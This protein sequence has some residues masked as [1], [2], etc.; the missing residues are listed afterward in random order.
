[1]CASSSAIFALTPSGPIGA[2]SSAYIFAD[3]DTALDNVMNAVAVGFI[4]ELDDVMYMQFLTAHDRASYEAQQASSPR[5]GFAHVVAGGAQI[6]SLCT[7]LV[8]ILGAGV[9]LTPASQHTRSAHRVLLDACRFHAC[10]HGVPV[11]YR[12][13]G[14]VQRGRC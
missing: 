6:V 4:V 13:V 9:L 11:R 14:P 7:I 12:V 5:G 3:A 1:M 2:V 10:D 8:C